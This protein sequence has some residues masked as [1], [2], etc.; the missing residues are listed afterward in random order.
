MERREEK[1]STFKSNSEKENGLVFEGFP[2]NTLSVKQ[3]E[4]GYRFSIDALMLAHHVNPNR[5]QRILDLGTGCGIISLILARRFPDIKIYGIEIQES[6]A[7][8]AKFNIFENKLEDQIKVICADMK[9]IFPKDIEGPVDMVVVNPPF[10][11]FGHSRFG[12]D[13][14]KA[15]AKHEI[16]ATLSD[17]IEF[18]GRVLKIFGSIL[19]IYPAQRLTD[20]FCTLRTEKLEPKWFRTIHPRHHADA[21]R[22][23]VRAVKHG[24]EGITIG[25]P[26]YVHGEDGSYMPEIEKMFRI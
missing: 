18:A 16:F 22:I 20:L 6:L 8:L 13:M 23:I 2:N 26:L 3:P 24:R 17:V 7:R 4:K 10:G 21:N 19:V 12:H 5:N 15:A 1:Y 25:S 11:K 14:A 9:R